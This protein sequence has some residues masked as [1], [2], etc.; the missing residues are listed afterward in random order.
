MVLLQF[1]QLIH[2]A[3]DNRF[4]DMHEFHSSQLKL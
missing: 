2:L 3:V 4:N 1:T